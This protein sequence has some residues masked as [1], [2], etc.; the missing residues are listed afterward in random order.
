M[1]ADLVAFCAPTPSSKFF[2]SRLSVKIIAVIVS[3][4][5]L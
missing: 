2:I 3:A 5:K 4:F 1:S